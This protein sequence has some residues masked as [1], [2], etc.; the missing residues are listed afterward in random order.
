MSGSEGSPAFFGRATERAQLEA[1]L[2]TARSGESATLVIRGDAGVGKSALLDF[3]ASQASGMTVLEVRATEA[4]SD[5]AF[6]G[7]YSLLRPILDKLPQLPERQARALA[8][9]FG[10]AESHSPDRFLISA[11][12]LS[13]L[14]VAAEERPVLC[15][16]DDAHWLDQPS[17][18]AMIFAARRLRADPVALVITASEW[19]GRRFDAPGLPELSLRGLDSV[20]AERI[21]DEAAPSLAPT[22]RA[23]LLADAEGNP[24][25]L[26]ELAHGLSEDERD[27][28]QALPEQ[29][30]LTPRLRD[31]F[32]RRIR[33]LPTPGRDALLVCALDG[34]ADAG[35]VLA[36]LAEIGLA[37]DSLAAAEQAGL[38][39][40]SGGR[41]GFLHPLVRAAA[42]EAAPLAQ[43][44]HVHLALAEALGEEQVDRRV[45]HQAMAALTG[46]EEVAA[47]LEA[48]AWRAQQRAGYASAAS[49][50][51]R[52]AELSRDE[53]R[54]ARRLADAAD[55][56]WNAGQIERAHALV[57]RALQFASGDL[58]PR[59]LHLRGSI[60]LAQGKLRDGT[61]TLLAAANASNDPSTTLAILTELVEPALVAGLPEEFAVA[62][63]NQAAA[64]P[65]KTSR[66]A[67]NQASLL[68]RQRR[69]ERRFEDSM[70]FYEEAMRHAAGLVDDVQVQYQAGALTMMTVGLGAGLAHVSRAVD[71]ARRQG[72]VGLLPNLLS[73]QSFEL[74]ATSQ[75]DSAYA[76][77][78]EGLELAL[79]TGQ[80]PVWHLLSLAWVEAVRGD[81]EAVRAHIDEATSRA[82]DSY[83]VAM[84]AGVVR[85]LLE[86]G[87]GNPDAAADA[88]L[89]ASPGD[90]LA[91]AWTAAV[92]DL[93]EAIVRAS[94]PSSAETD[95]LLARLRRAQSTSRG[96]ASLLAR[97]EALLGKRPPAEA[98]AEA[99]ELADALSPFERARTELL[100]GEWLRR[101]RRRREARPHL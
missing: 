51:Q 62:A 68:W 12:V 6:A 72:R 93:V 35:V 61:A 91:V 23:R 45:W 13:L 95:T 47:A 42:V 82:G 71:V 69:F 8:A 63:G 15:L 94:H 84:A 33:L 89:S 46:D 19:E 64:L 56:A 97:C 59:L 37:A 16:V 34:T 39:R 81:G 55:A 101:E 4:E 18:E 50:F 2:T 52:A 57:E 76:T 3:A 58:Q 99:L 44:Q 27:G 60:E 32:E 36:A 88:M 65:T 10:L 22:V 1:L 90:R 43:R 31:L 38:V 70:R 73:L 14:A 49:A 20:S 83:M 92:P 85:G 75:F 87:C 66:D 5:L 21:L 53:T 78:G 17:A 67:F 40:T 100:Y 25:A 79:H 86:L 41:I 96:F 29:L 11:A 80:S 9:A 54:L 48:S 26:H 7:L 24:L 28:R 74:A 77:A 30:P 98:Y